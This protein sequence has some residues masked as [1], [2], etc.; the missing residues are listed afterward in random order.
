V[1]FDVLAE[2]ESRSDCADL[3]PEVGPEVAGIGF[4]EPFSG[5]TPRLARV[6]AT[7]DIHHAVKRFSR[8]ASQIAPDWSR[9]KV[10]R[11]NL[12]SQVFDGEG[13]DL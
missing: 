4:P 2:N 3:L 11:L 8:E 13:F 1:A 7:E 9:G 6:P 12:C 5:R 10:S